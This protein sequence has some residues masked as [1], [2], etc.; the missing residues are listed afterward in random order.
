MAKVKFGVIADLHGEIMPDGMDRLNKFLLDADAED[1]D[2]VVQLGDFCSAGSR[3][4]LAC[5]DCDTPVNV[6][7]LHTKTPPADMNGMIK[8]YVNYRKPSYS[9]IGNHD[10][11]MWY[12]APVLESYNMPGSFYSV[13]ACGFHLIFLD[14]NYYRDE[15]GSFIAYEGGNYFSHDDLPYIPPHELEWIKNDII[16]TDLPVLIFSHQSIAH[17]ELG[18]KNSLQLRETL[19]ELKNAGKRILMALNGHNHTDGLVE[20][21]DTVFFDVNSASNYWGGQKYACMRYSIEVDENFPSVRYTFPYT[22]PLYAFVSIDSER[23]IEI[24]G[25]SANFFGKTPTDLGHIGFGG[26]SKITPSIKS[27]RIFIGNG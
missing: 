20:I 15:N 26:W 2:F 19:R 23:Y 24:K 11:D 4:A 8:R 18:I 13:D 5:D 12:R 21:D 14:C 22:E 1:A 27:R 7:N 6:A 10:A 17:P 16:H 25:K 9:V 3:N